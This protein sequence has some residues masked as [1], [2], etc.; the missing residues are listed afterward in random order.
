MSISLLVAGLACVGM[1]VGH[2]AIGHLWVLP[3]LT[4]DRVAA[5]PFGPPRLTVG[6][7]RI[8]WHI[9]SLFCLSFAVILLTMA[10]A[11]APDLRTLVLRTVAC[12]FVAAAVMAVAI[13]GFRLKYLVKL[14]VPLV[15]IGIAVLCWVAS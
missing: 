5:T 15:W 13:I 6:L 12:M 8:T 4:T 9:V 11:D 2:S 14:P 7:L 1:T 10:T 3:H